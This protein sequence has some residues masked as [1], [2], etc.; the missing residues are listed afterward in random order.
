MENVFI[1]ELKTVIG[2]KISIT[3]IN[4]YF[5]PNMYLVEAQLATCFGLPI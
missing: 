3:S 4:G 1:G 5:D 2:H